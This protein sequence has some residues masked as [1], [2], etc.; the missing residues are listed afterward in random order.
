MKPIQL[1]EEQNI[2]RN[3]QINNRL[4]RPVFDPFEH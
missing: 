1:S 4:V 3:E 2:K